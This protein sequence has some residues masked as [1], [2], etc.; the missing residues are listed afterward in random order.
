MSNVS[1]R[2]QVLRDQRVLFLAICFLIP[3]VWLYAVFSDRQTLPKLKMTAGV[4]NGLRHQLALELARE[5]GK[6]GIPVEVIPTEGSAK[7]IEQIS[8]NAIDLALVQGGA[9]YHRL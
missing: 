3:S 8:T 2:S 1:Q 6:K 9:Q 4:A 5:L 7:A